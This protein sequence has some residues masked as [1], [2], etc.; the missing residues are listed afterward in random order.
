LDID[1]IINNSIER[2]K[3]KI[4]IDEDL[5]DKN[6]SEIHK[7]INTTDRKK[8]EKGTTY[9][10]R[11]YFKELTAVAAFIAIL[12]LIPTITQQYK[13]K[14]VKTPDDNPTIVNNSKGIK[15][16]D[17]DKTIGSI[18]IN[19]DYKEQKRAEKA[20]EQIAKKH[21]GN[22][23]ISYIGKS[24]AGAVNDN[25]NTFYHEFEVYEITKNKR[26]S[27]IKLKIKE[28]TDEAY[29]YST[30][31]NGI[32]QVT[33]NMT[34]DR[35]MGSGSIDKESAKALIDNKIDFDGGSFNIV[36][37]N[38]YYRVVDKNT[39]IEYR[40]N[41]DTQD[42]YKINKNNKEELVYKN[43][44]N[45]K[46]VT[47]EFNEDI[48]GDGKPESIKYD[49]YNHTLT[50]DNMSILVFATIARG[51]VSI[52]DI[53]KKDSMKEMVLNTG[54]GELGS[55]YLYYF[56]G[57]TFVA[58]HRFTGKDISAD[59]TGVFKLIGSPAKTL[60]CWIND[61]LYKL[62]DHYAFEEVPQEYE[63]NQ[64]L[65]VKKPLSLQKS[66]T[67][68]EIVE[69]LQPGEN[70]QLVKTDDTNWYCAK[71]SKGILGWFEVD[72]YKI[73]EL[74]LFA[75]DVFDGLIFRD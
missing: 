59:G 11:T 54:G 37:E 60:Q 40:V 69:T 8:K 14:N 35:R 39:G 72:V 61:K 63:L 57:A 6:W 66:K 71:S 25:P 46:K 33:N 20:V 5:F 65:I 56:D 3:K 27:Y 74:N 68:K 29:V 42:I 30:N 18:D 34:L 51:K 64:K 23:M 44:L 45:N 22:F 13:D 12:I 32:V 41:S 9:F 15:V 19:S 10:I 2:E 26:P 4:R 38:Q 17:Y 53:N 16:E 50:V 62:T 52:L 24:K 28:N 67:D 47:V 70:I 49:Y 55:I 7:K 1:K 31:K 48:N 36:G 58:M 43:Q 21:Y 75:G 73:K